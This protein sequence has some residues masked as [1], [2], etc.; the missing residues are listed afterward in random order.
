MS[1]LYEIMGTVLPA[2]GQFA[3]SAYGDNSLLHA[4]GRGWAIVLDSETLPQRSSTPP[5]S[6]QKAVN[7]VDNLQREQENMLI[8]GV[9]FVKE[10]DVVTIVSGD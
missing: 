10:N 8:R 2:H 7:K 3:A 6:L 5:A 9:K 1:A 4:A